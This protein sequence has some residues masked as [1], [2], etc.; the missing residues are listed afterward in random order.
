MRNTLSPERLFGICKGKPSPRKSRTPI[1]KDAQPDPIYRTKRLNLKRALRAV[2]AHNRFHPKHP[3]R[4]AT[5]DKRHALEVQPRPCFRRFCEFM[6]WPAFF[7][8]YTA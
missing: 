6:G 1:I 5:P 7:F 3:H 8:G 2:A 4:A